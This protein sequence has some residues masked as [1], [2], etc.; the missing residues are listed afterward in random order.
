MTDQHGW[1]CLALAPG[2]GPGL[3][4]RLLACY[5][6]PAAI[7]AADKKALLQVPGIGHKSVAGLDYQLLAQEANRQL[8]Q[9]QQH[10][11]TVVTLDDER[12]PRLLRQIYRPPLLLFVQGD[13]AQLDR[14]AVA[15][16]GSR[17]ATSY[18]RKMASSLAQELAAAGLTVVSGVALGIDGA[19]H[20]GAV[21]TGKTIGVL[22]CGLDVV[23][24]RQH[25]NLYGQIA[26]Q[27]AL[28]S[29]YP[30][31]TRPEPFRFPARNRIISGLSL[32]TVVVEAARR[33]GSLITAQLALEQ[34]RDVFAVP[35][36]IDSARS[37]GVHKLLQEGAT[38]VS[39][40]EDIVVAL[41]GHREEKNDSPGLVEP[42]LG[43]DE[44]KIYELL[45][46]YGLSID[47]V[48]QLAGMRAEKVAEVLLLLEL[49][50]LIS[51]Q[52]G[53]IFQ[54]LKE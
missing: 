6:T 21:Q 48:I 1:L 4:H 53:N 3:A 14:P 35:G 11:V 2:L 44:K 32:G 7:L 15:M 28:V 23:Y 30:F 20:S 49:R 19:A 38:L 9:A 46:V 12:Y 33:S 29:E 34:G 5:G 25:K 18:G 26:E 10:G 51:A 22:G 42:R 47:E 52:P 27:G 16:V 50:G 17:A 45:D 13:V 8:Q 31:A 54:R 41:A 39:A 37:D 24:P 40:V 36:R 43:N